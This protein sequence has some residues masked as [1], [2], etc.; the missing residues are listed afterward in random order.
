MSCSGKLWRLDLRCNHEDLSPLIS[1]VTL[2]GTVLHTAQLLELN[3]KKVINVEVK[4]KIKG[5][6]WKK[7]EFA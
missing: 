7:M 1:G 6:K 5:H 4:W 2:S 3:N